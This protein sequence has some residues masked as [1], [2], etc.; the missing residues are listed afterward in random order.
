MTI[1]IFDL[2][3]KNTDFSISNMSL[4]IENE[5]TISY[6]DIDTLALKK[7]NNKISFYGKNNEKNNSTPKFDFILNTTQIIQAD[8]TKSFSSKGFLKYYGNSEYIDSNLPFKFRGLSS[9]S[10]LQM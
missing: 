9:L 4:K 1:T 3:P 8:N 7:S 2:L 10:K 5:G 6:Y